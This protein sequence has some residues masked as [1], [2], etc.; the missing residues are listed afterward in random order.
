MTITNTQTTELSL[1]QLDDISAGFIGAALR[2]A[3]GAAK[4][5]HAV[6]RFSAKFGLKGFCWALKPSYL[7]ETFRYMSSPM[8]G[9]LRAVAGPAATTAQCIG[10]GAK[11]VGTGAVVA[12][13]IINAGSITKSAK[14]FFGSVFG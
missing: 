12:T 1:D 13:A 5:V 10:L 4:T 14:G 6:G 11:I 8:G 3:T 2:G 9:S 7:S